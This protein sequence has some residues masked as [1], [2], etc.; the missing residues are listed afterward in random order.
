MNN[1]SNKKQKREH[2]L[3][4]ALS[5]TFITIL[6][7]VIATATAFVCVLY[8][9]TADVDK[10]KLECTSADVIICDNKG[11]SLPLPASMDKNTSPDEIPENL[12][13]AFVSLE[14][15]RFYSH[16]GIDYI[17]IFGAM[18]SNLR[19]GKYKE[20][21]STIS[22]QLIKNTHLSAEKSLS[23][24]IEEAQLAIKLEKTY[25]K[26]QILAMYMNMLYF[27]SG[28]YGVKN[29]ARRFFGKELGE[30]N[31]AECAMLAG[32]VKS[33]TK[34]NPINNYDNSIERMR[35]V[36]GVMLDNGS[37]TQAEYN[38]AISQDIIIKNDIN[39]N[40]LA[41]KLLFYALEEASE[42]TSTSM[43][44]LLSSGYTIKTYTDC[45]A[46]SQLIETISEESLYIKNLSDSIPDCMGIMFDNKTGGVKA[47]YANCD[48]SPLHTRRQPGSTIKPLV[49]YTPAMNE[50][51]I[52]PAT[53][54]C[55]APQDFYGYKP[56]NFNDK[57]YGDVSVRRCVELSLNV[58]AVE[59]MNRIGIEQAC[60][61]LKNMNISL[62]ERDYNYSTALGGMTYGITA[63]EMG[64]AYMTLA[65]G[66][67]YVKPS[68]VQEIKDKDGNVI[69]SNNNEYTSV[70]SPASS[71]LMTDM[72]ISTAKEG[73]AKKLSSLPYNIASK[74]GTV[75]CTFDKQ[76]NSDAY[77]VSYSSLDTLIVWQGNLSCEESDMLTSRT[78]GGGSPTLMAAKIWNDYYSCNA[79]EPF[80]KPSG[81]AGIDIDK[82]SLSKGILTIADSCAPAYAKTAE[83]FDIRYIPDTID[84]SYTN[85]APLSL[86]AVTNDNG[87]TI[88]LQSNPRLGYLITKRAFLSDE[89]V[90]ADLCENNDSY[91][92]TDH[93]PIGIF[94]PVYTVLPYYFDDAGNQIFGAP[95]VITISYSE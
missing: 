82:F 62:D 77:N 47:F 34:Y 61:Y 1:K 75:A 50:G 55:D 25:T 63:L 57:Y 80:I 22:Q 38:E 24:K 56:S 5:V 41:D 51:V 18:I 78:T 14:D 94:P 12:K 6:L 17:R 16:H 49:C 10:S 71:Y 87:T 59:V 45:I 9:S 73:S 46:Q 20:G 95:Q 8:C 70:F 43:E 84:D 42:V 67:N 53:R 58:P 37:L 23:R 4:K 39:K 36:L 19:A 54:I 64:G 2:T 21:A 33:P 88:T 26:D 92:V 89:T 28:E 85:P 74:T 13:S 69:Y 31:N 29:A 52:Q 66:G 44:Q 60:T 76:F 81:V 15:K 79:P 32:I 3:A 40:N 27:G 65:R 35:L 11:K 83:L 86:S 30:L 68:F 7:I 91:T 48:Y 72:L 93:A 90:I